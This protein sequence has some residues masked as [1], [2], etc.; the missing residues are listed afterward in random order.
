MKKFLIMLLVVVSCLSCMII[1]TTAAEKTFRIGYSMPSL[2]AD[3]WVIMNEGVLEQ[4]AKHPEVTLIRTES[5]GNTAKQ[6]SDVND[7]LTQGIDLLLL[8]PNESQPLVT[9]LEAAYRAKVPVI[10][11][12]IPVSGEKKICHIAGDHY[13]NGKVNA[14]ECVRKLTEKYG[15]PKG[16]VLQI[17]GPLGIDTV[18]LRKAGFDDVMVNYPNIKVIGNQTGEWKA[19]K[20]YNIAKD[21]LTSNPEIDAI[22]SHNDGMII[23]VLRAIEEADKLGKIFT[24][25]IDGDARVLQAIKEGSATALATYSH[26]LG[27]KAFEV[28][29][30]WLN[31]EDVPY[32]IIMPTY[33]VNA[34]NVDKFFD[35]NSPAY[36]EPT[37]S[38][39]VPPQLI[40]ERPPEAQAYYDE[41]KKLR[42]SK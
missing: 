11:W 17:Q 13:G 21:Y 35:P 27:V 39:A 18:T 10:N 38:A 12:D 8:F 32:T 9:A 28:A 6:I 16:T 41:L 22:Y 5:G 40:S 31:G 26:A 30:Q 36:V 20:A 42:D 14:E 15:E 33:L 37:D 29:L 3:W 34:A 25:S 4:A 23:G 1:V 19:D 24:F 7:L 2:E